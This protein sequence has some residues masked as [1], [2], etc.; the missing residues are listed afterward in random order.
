MKTIIAAGIV[1]VASASHCNQICDAK[2]DAQNFWSSRLAN[3]F[4]LE[5]RL[6]CESKQQ[7]QLM[8][9]QDYTC[10]EICAAKTKAQRFK[11]E[12][13]A[14]SFYLECTLECGAYQ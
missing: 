14:E 13:L 4:N 6:D 1:A 9:L 12:R 3:S 10:P 8:N 11:I 2:T 7:P 5:C